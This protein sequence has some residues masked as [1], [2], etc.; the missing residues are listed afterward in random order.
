MT[1]SSLAAL[2]SSGAPPRLFPS[3]VAQHTLTFE[4]NG[5]IPL[6]DLFPGAVLHPSLSRA[7][8][9]RQAE[10][11]AGR[12][13]ARRALAE[14]APE[15]ADWAVDI[16]PQREPVWPPGI[17]GTITHT[18]GFASAAVA[19]KGEARSIGLDVE[20]FLDDRQA[21]RLVARIADDI[22]VSAVARATGWS[23][24]VALT[25]IF[26]AKETLFK[27]LYPEAKRYF[28][29]RDAWVEAFLPPG[30][31]FR[32]RLLAELTA[33][34]P[35]GRAFLGRFSIEPGVVHTAMVLPETSSCP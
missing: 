21:D 32:V 29:F 7:V 6:S 13:C 27:C 1:G 24:A 3:F 22:E 18:E 28:G 8:R 35:A 16:G 31:T 23:A 4:V 34:L 19:R 10:F 15:H 30:G 12:F 17:T 2:P 33:W 20:H 26:S 25:A 9:K 11:L 14:C 5:P